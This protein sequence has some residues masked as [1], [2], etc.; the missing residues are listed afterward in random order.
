MTLDAD[1][2]ALI[3]RKMRERGTSFEETVNEA[4]R[5]GPRSPGHAPAVR[6]AD[7]RPGP[8]RGELGAGTRRGVRARRRRASLQA[9]RRNVRLVHANVLLNTVNGAERRHGESREW[10]DA[11]LSGAGTIRFAWGPRHSGLEHDLRAVGRPACAARRAS[12]RDR[13]NLGCGLRD[14]IAHEAG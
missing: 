8:A 7:G 10:L 9:A 3:E 14:V 12:A 2:E 13:D 5:R 4:I 1:T 6:D 11:S